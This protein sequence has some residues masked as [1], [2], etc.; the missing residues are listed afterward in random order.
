MMLA[1]EVSIDGQAPVVA[2]VED[3]SILFLHVTARR[4]GNPGTGDK[5]RVEASVG[6]LSLSDA[7]N[8]S[9]HFRWS[10]KSLDIGSVVSIRVVDALEVD[11]PAKRY[12]SDREVRESPFT[13]E[14]WRRMRYND[15]LALRKEFEP[16][17]A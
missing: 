11:A 8:V 7:A 12:R 1:F 2:G 15:Y 16:Q 3:W 5:D 14:E 13:E 6:G 10:E 9:H 4:A 17:S